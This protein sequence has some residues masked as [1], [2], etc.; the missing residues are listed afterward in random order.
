MNHEKIYLYDSFSGSHA[1]V[2]AKLRG[3]EVQGR[4]FQGVLF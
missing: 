4:L 3:E 1:C 2:Y